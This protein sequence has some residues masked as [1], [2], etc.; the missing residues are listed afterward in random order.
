MNAHEWLQTIIF[1]CGLAGLGQAAGQFHGEGVP[2]E[3]TFLSPLL[4][5]VILFIQIASF[6]VL[7]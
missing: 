7:Q 1:F 4:L 2:G 3:Q 5:G 6:A